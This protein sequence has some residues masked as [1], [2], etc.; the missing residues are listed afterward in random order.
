LAA[1]AGEIVE[2]LNY[3]IDWL[4]DE[5]WRLA[6][7]ERINPVLNAA[8]REN[9]GPSLD[10]LGGTPGR[11][12]S[13]YAP[14]RSGVTDIT[15]SPDP[16][17]P[18]GDGRDDV[19]LISGHLDLFSARIKAQIFDIKGRRIRTLEDNQFSGNRFTL[20]WDGREDNRQTAR[21]GIYII[22]LQILNARQGIIKEM[23]TTVVLAQKM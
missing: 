21:I 10:I 14:L 4:E 1:P 16:F 9:W 12:N 11:K 22:Y 23:K 15:V 6:S 8:R 20:V 3:Q 7:L 19:T 2:E 18:D 17:S 13:L 5:D